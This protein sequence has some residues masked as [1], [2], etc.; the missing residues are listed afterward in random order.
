MFKMSKWPLFC[1][2]VKNSAFKNLN[3]VYVNTILRTMF[4]SVFHSFQFRFFIVAVQRNST[5]I[6]WKHHCCIY[7]NFIFLTCLLLS[8][9]SLTSL[10]TVFV[11]CLIHFSASGL[12]NLF[13]STTFLMIHYL[14]T[15][16]SQLSH[17]LLVLLSSYLKA[18]LSNRAAI[19]QFSSSLTPYICPLWNNFSFLCC[20]FYFIQFSELII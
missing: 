13:A 7:L 19:T 14:A 2:S 17:W 5:N 6:V 3:V 20:F 1:S 16:N 8:S 11:I 12:H 18:P 9:S 10:C 4:T 15:Q